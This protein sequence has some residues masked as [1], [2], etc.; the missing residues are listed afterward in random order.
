MSEKTKQKERLKSAKVIR[1]EAK[2]NYKIKIITHINND[3]IVI[4]VDE[5]ERWL[6]MKRVKELK[7]NLQLPMEV[8]DVIIEARIRRARERQRLPCTMKDEEED[9]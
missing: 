3:I 6:R 7:E 4:A 9:E 5:A 2:I 1:D 8:L